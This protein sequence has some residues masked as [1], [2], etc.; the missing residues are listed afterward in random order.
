MRV[1]ASAQV[2]R[3][4]KSTC[5]DKSTEGYLAMTSL[6]PN[7]EHLPQS[8]IKT[9]LGIGW[10]NAGKV[11][12]RVALSRRVYRKKLTPERVNDI[13]KFY[14]RPDISHIELSKKA[15]KNMG[16]EDI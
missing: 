15:S 11:K 2:V 10:D 5:G 1:E 14:E 9:I 16:L 6:S 3:H 4:I 12:S 7:F 13:V 8:K